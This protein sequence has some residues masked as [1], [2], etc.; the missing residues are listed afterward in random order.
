M[1]RYIS[2]DTIELHEPSRTSNLRINPP[3]VLAVP[4]K[5]ITLKVTITCDVTTSGTR[6]G[7][8]V[9]QLYTHELV[10]KCHH[11]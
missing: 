6:E 1:A 8:E 10:T 9:V 5:A 3:V 2:L 4:G 7:D 11:L